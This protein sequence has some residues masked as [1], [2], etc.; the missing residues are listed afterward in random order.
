VISHVFLL[1]ALRAHFSHSCAYTWTRK[2]R[3]NDQ[4]RLLEEGSAVEKGVRHERMKDD[5]RRLQSSH[6]ILHLT[7]FQ[8]RLSHYC[9]QLMCFVQ[10]QSEV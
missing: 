6:I 8:K 5:W 9:L 10:L 4:P 1:C 2:K 3:W 7:F